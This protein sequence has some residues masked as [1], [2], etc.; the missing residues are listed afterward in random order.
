MNILGLKWKI[1]AGLGGALTIAAS[2]ALL[3]AYI[4]N[5]NLREANKK[6]DDRI[7]NPVTGYIAEGARKD[8]NYTNLKRAADRQTAALKT[9]SAADLARLRAT[10]AKLAAAQRLTRD[11]QRESDV[12]LATPPQGATICEQFEDVDRRVMENLK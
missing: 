12:M 11:A 3:V 1:L 7:N 8:A 10:E 4:E 5:G 2:I 9:Q 6:L